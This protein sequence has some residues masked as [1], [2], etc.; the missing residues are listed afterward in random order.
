MSVVDQPPQP[1]DDS[2]LAMALA[3]G[4][5]HAAAA[6]RAQISERTVRRKLADP[7]FRALVGEY[8]NQLI[9]GALGRMA[10][11][12]TRAA[13]TLAA[14]LDAP[15]A[16]LRARAARAVLS[17]TLRLQDSVDTNNRIRELELELARKQGSAV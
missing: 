13:D 3:A 2:V 7:A 9:A 14:L 16:H 8:R 17:L 6:E 4:A 12:M 10:E 1:I 11:N 5:T 15:E